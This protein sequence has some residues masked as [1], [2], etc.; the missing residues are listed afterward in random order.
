MDI[1]NSGTVNWRHNYNLICQISTVYEMYWYD[2]DNGVICYYKW[3]SILF[4]VIQLLH[5][6]CV[7]L[8]AFHMAS[9]YHYKFVYFYQHWFNKFVSGHVFF[10]V[11]TDETY[12]LLFIARN[13]QDEFLWWSW[14]VSCKLKTMLV[15]LSQPCCVFY[16]A[17]RFQR[18]A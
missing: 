1:N 15:P 10:V 2:E 14:V 5:N 6:D 12:D 7:G 3:Y 13:S 18:N 11:Y 8:L 16:A 9:S 4:F 17:L